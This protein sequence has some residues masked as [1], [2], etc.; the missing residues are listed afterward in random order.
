MSGQQSHAS[1]HQPG[2]IVSRKT[3]PKSPTVYVLEG[4]LGETRIRSVRRTDHWGTWDESVGKNMMEPFTRARLIKSRI[5]LLYFLWSTVR[6][7]IYS[8]LQY[9]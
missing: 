1:Q 3:Q 4:L 9:S 7:S 8:Y 6:V 5:L 2:G